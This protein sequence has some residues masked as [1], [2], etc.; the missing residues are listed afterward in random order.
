[1]AKRPFV[2]N[3]FLTGITLAF[4]NPST[5]LIADTVLPRVPV[6]KETFA[7]N[8]FPDSDAFTVP[9]TLV[10]RAGRVNEVEFTADRKEASTEDH[11]L[12]DPIPYS[13]I[14][15]ADGTGNDPEGRATEVLTDLLLLGREVRAANL[16]FNA[17][18]YAAANKTTLAGNTQWSDTANSDPVKALEDAIDS[19]L[20][21]PNQLILGKAVWS[22]LKRHPKVIA[23][24]LGAANTS[25]RVRAQDLAEVLELEKIVVGEGWI[26]TARKGQAAVMARAWGKHAA[27]VYTNPMADTERGIT[28]GL[29]AQR[30]TRIAGRFED[31]KFG[32]EGGVR[33]RVGERVKELVVAPSAGYFFQNAIG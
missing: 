5:A 25:G 8:T 11:G 30:K 22:I 26:N 33:I 31:E 19:M 27:L 13:D 24:V 6:G 12:E 18:S 7:Y 9:D 16:V 17:N 23:A 1:M 20:V 32:L 3:P 29:T 10:G 28:F 15:E 21:K 2:T 4:K 14:E